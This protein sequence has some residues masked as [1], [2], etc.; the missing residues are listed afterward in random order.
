LA[1]S[2]GDHPLLVVAL[3]AAFIRHAGT[4]GTLRRLTKFYADLYNICPSPHIVVLAE[5]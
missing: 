4:S 2:Q 3:N 5:G 1:A